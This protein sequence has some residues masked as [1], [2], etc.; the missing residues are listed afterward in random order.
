[1][2]L[3]FRGGWKKPKG[4]GTGADEEDVD[5]HA[6]AF[7]LG[8]RWIS[9]LGVGVA[10]EGREGAGRRNRDRKIAGTI[11]DAPS[12]NN[13]IPVIRG[14][15]TPLSR[16]SGGFDATDRIPSFVLDRGGESPIGSLG[17]PDWRTGS[18]LLCCR[19]HKPG[20]RWTDV[21]GGGPR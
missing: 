21:A 19:A 16:S 18:A 11:G 1:M 17:G 9:F 6:F 13:G 8:H 20:A 15:E 5:L 10:G 12:R 4:R 2:D 3:G 7:G 14:R